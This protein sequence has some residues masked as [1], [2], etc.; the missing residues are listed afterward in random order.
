MILTKDNFETVIAENKYVFVK[1]YAPWCGHCKK[2]AP[3]YNELA[4]KY[5]KEGSVVIAKLDAT[6]EGEVGTKHNVKGFPTLKLFIS[7]NPIDYTNQR[8]L[9]AMDSWL[10]KKI[11]QSL[12]VLSTEDE[13]NNYM[14]K[15]LFVGLISSE[16]NDE[17]IEAFSSVCANFDSIDCVRIDNSFKSKFNITNDLSLI[18]YK[19]TDEG[20]KILSKNLSFTNMNEFIDFH[21]FDTVSQFNQA[22]AEYIFGKEKVAFFIFNDNKE[23]EQISAFA[24][25]A[26]E[27]KGKYVFSKSEITKDLGQRLAEFVGVT[28]E[29]ANTVRGIKFVKGN[30]QKYQLNNVTVESFK[31]FIS[32]FEDDKI[33]PYFK[34]EE[35]PESNEESVKT[36][37]GKNFEEMVLSDNNS[38]LLEAYAPWCGHC[39]QLEPIYK[40]LAEKFKSNSDIVIAKIDATANEHSLLQVKGFPTIKFYKK[41]S[42]TA[43]TDYSG[44]RTL[45]A[46]TQ[47]L[48]EQLGIKADDTVTTDL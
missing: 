27:F 32:D 39:K 43:P 8:D 48:N 24:Q 35:I 44:E 5:Q 21:R 6:V 10:Q 13:V 9:D 15:E 7:G 11:N 36:V 40:E 4:I 16:S 18:V 42:K 46:M 37:V 47:F 33:D 28:P 45:E 31:Q 1:F 3:D 26:F 23:S 20:S 19:T 41:G 22:T 34:S 30:L 2:M 25:V 14:K 29:H 38:V 17:T 12:K